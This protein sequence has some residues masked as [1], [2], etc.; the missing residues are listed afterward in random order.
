M[1]VSKRE[2]C[3]CLCY[4]FPISM[5]YI[6]MSAIL[7]QQV[8][9][10][11]LLSDFLF[12]TNICSSH[13]LSLSFSVSLHS[14]QFCSSQCFQFGG[15]ISYCFEIKHLQPYLFI[16]ANTHACTQILKDTYAG[17]KMYDKEAD[18]IICFLNNIFMFNNEHRWW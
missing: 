16:W 17:L 2:D 1:E 14:R 6:Y 4:H 18:N 12:A 11:L 3:V 15:V 10:Q 5:A 9:C 7:M 8:F 13:T